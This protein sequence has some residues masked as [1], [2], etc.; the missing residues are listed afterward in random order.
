[1]AVHIVGSN[2]DNFELDFNNCWIYHF[3]FNVNINVE[4]I[5]S[6]FK[7]V[8][9]NH[10]KTLSSFKETPLETLIFS[11]FDVSQSSK[12][13]SKPLD[14]AAVAAFFIPEKKVSE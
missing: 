9:I 8:L 6:I 2:A 14:R 4:E 5:L 13:T 7:Y 3:K 11:F 1:M 10:F 12:F